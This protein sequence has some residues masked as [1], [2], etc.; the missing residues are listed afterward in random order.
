MKISF[1]FLP[2]FLS[3]LLILPGLTLAAGLVDQVP[4]AFEVVFGKK[5]TATELAYWKGRV[6]SGEKKTYEALV[7]A[8]SY[9]KARG[10]TGVAAPKTAVKT[11]NKQAM[12]VEVLPMFVRI[13]GNNPSNAEKVW[14]RAR[15]SCNEIKSF[16]ALENSMNFHKSKGKRKGSDGI[17]GGAFASAA[18]ASSGSS[19]VARHAVAGVSD[20]PQGDDIRVGIFS[21]PLSAMEVTVNGPYQI[22]AGREDVLATLGKDDVVKVSWSGGK[23]HVRGSGIQEDPTDVVRIV[24]TGGGIIQLKNYS[25]PSKTYPGKNYNRFRGIMEIR[26]CTGCNELWAVN[27][28]RI[29]PYLKGLGET[30][31]EGP[32][33]YIKALGIAARTYAIYHKVVTGGRNVQKG[34]DLTNTPND[35]I[36]RGYEYEIITSRMSS[37]FAKV[38]GVIVTD[39]GGDAPLSTVYFSDSDGRTRSAKEAW[40]TSR[41]PHLQ[42]SVKDPYHVS[43]ICLGHCVGM[44]AQG[45]Y[46]LASKESWDFKKI[47]TYYY[48]GIKLVKAY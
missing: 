30:S 44:S 47:L 46:G 43:S 13:Y 35:Q 16:A 19:G 15:I 32:E 36:Y 4:K 34:Y 24:P 7:G 21:T 17:C 11:D 1:L 12:I 22:R 26:K 5:P 37:I 42:K 31:G 40:N 33:E 14:W 9:Q 27:E 20:H 25:D 41:F 8:M 38:R 39:G 23:Y 29:E 6:T 2:I 48:S 18:S 45:A 28:L 10:S 3:L